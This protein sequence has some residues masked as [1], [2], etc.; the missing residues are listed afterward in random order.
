MAPA[1]PFRVHYAA[2]GD[3]QIKVVQADTPEAARDCIR[4]ACLPDPV[5][6]HKVK[7]DRSERRA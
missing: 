5:I 6:F 1:I 4:I 7:V 3:D 2:G